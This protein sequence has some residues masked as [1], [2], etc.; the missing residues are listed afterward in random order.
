M[1]ARGSLI[2]GHEAL[3]DERVHGVWEQGRPG[4]L[5]LVLGGLHG[6]EPAGVLA[7]ARVLAELRQRET[8]IR[9]RFVAL[10]GNK[11]A[12]QM[13][14][15]YLDRDL[16]RAWTDERVDKLQRQAPEEDRAEDREQRELWGAL[17]EH[18]D[19]QA[20]S[21]VGLLDLHSTS[22][23]GCPF[24]IMADTL[25]NRRLALALPVPLLLGLEESVDG[26]LLAW[27]G[28]KGHVA[29]CLEGGQNE[30]ESTVDHHAA[31]IWLGLEA[32]GL[33]A[34]EDVPD[35]EGLRDLLGQTAWGMPEVVEIR[36]RHGI[37]SGEVFEMEPGYTNF[38]L[39][40]KGEV[41]AW[42]GEERERVVR[43]PLTGLLLMPRYQGQGNDGFFLG[44]EVQPFWMRL[45]AF[46][47]RL[48][49]GGLLRFLP[50]VHRH[51]HNPRV[52]LVDPR[53]ARFGVVDVF[54]LFGFRRSRKVEGFLVF[55]RR[56][57]A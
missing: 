10:V 7:A 1:V 3:L 17:R 12:L 48:R 46:L 37:A 28:E 24:T 34:A 42:S 25:Q 13:G 30:L 31:A 2:E 22:A 52:F 19:A 27:L 5:F 23:D 54:H 8:P 32:L 14:V 43:G 40:E 47:R 11:S 21:K 38:H 45:S 16:N 41:L 50:G 26:T 6:N 4:P 44:S 51:P 33:V 49:L 53:I 9:G 55:V 15:R 35:I 20:W 56:P 18:M 29:V 36:Y 57:E 39:V